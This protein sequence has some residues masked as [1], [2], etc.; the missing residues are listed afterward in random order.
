I[1][2]ALAYDPVL[3]RDLVAL[4]ADAL[5]ERSTTRIGF[6]QGSVLRQY[7]YDFVNLFAPH[8]TRERVDEL[9]AAPPEQRLAQVEAMRAELP[10]LGPAPWGHLGDLPA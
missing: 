9:I 5:F 10:T 7:M 8:L 4:E 1:V 2:A 6:R 3:D